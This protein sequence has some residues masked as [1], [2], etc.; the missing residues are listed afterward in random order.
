MV[1]RKF[2]RWYGLTG[3]VLLFRLPMFQK[4]ENRIESR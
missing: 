1:F 2:V 4:K 3:A